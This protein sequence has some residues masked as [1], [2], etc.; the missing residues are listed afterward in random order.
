LESNTSA[1]R[2]QSGERVELRLRRVPGE[3]EQDD[4]ENL[5]I[6]ESGHFTRGVGH[7]SRGLN[8]GWSER[9]EKELYNIAARRGERETF[10][11]MP[12][13]G[14][15]RGPERELILQAAKPPSGQ[16]DG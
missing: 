14:Q 3:T 11:W 7:R 9:A 1:Y 8:V 5:D 16:R 15:R 6:I 2:L 12:V 10:D 4:L 13:K